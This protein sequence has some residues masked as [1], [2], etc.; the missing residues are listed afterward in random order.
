MGSLVAHSPQKHPQQQK[1]DIIPKR[2]TAKFSWAG[3]ILSS[4][5]TSSNNTIAAGFR[6][7]Q[8]TG[9]TR[10]VMGS[11]ASAR[12]HLPMIFNRDGL[13]LAMLTQYTLFFLDID[14]N[15][16]FTSDTNQSKT[17]QI[18]FYYFI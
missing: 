11:P 3:C 9:N 1:Q 15:E 7:Q 14:A 16:Y 17:N 12:H 10:Y 18:N 8:H 4:G 6:T 5:S 2:P 13:S